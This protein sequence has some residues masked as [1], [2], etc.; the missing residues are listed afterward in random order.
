LNLYFSPDDPLLYG[1]QYGNIDANTTI[2]FFAFNRQ[3]GA[4]RLG[5]QV[6]LDGLYNAFPAERW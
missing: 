1:V 5:G 3:S 6:T 2:D 4:I